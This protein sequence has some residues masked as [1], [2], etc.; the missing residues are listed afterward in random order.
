MVLF[1]N[2]ILGISLMISVVW[3]LLW[4]LI[5]NVVLVPEGIEPQRFPVIAFLGPIL[6]ETAFKR[7]ALRQPDLLAT[8]SRKILLSDEPELKMKLSEER[9]LDKNTDQSARKEGARRYRIYGARKSGLKYPQPEPGVI[10][11][12]Q[13]PFKIEGPAKDRP[14]AGYPLEPTLPE[15]AKEKESLEFALILSFWISPEGTVV[16]VEPEILS[17]YPEIDLLAIRY[18][19]K[20]RFQ[21]LQAETEKVGQWGTIS[22]KLQ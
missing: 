12:P 15:W 9:V 22:F 18:V 21:P 2:R 16:G 20:L 17:G 8:L 1:R 13:F 5:P 19:H 7:K 6:E 10:S 11:R 14:L 4:G 3:H